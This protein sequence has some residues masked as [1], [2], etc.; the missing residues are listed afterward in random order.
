M[1]AVLSFAHSQWCKLFS[2]HLVSVPTPKATNWAMYISPF[3]SI[4][5]TVFSLCQHSQIFLSQGYRNGTFYGYSIACVRSKRLFSKCLS[6]N[7]LVFHVGFAWLFLKTHD[8][9]TSLHSRSHTFCSVSHVFWV[10]FSK[11]SFSTHFVPIG[12]VTDKVL[13]I[14]CWLHTKINQLF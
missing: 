11:A 2:R 4:G 12:S 10:T 3:S 1:Q 14:F 9:N 5:N 6:V 13:L 8:L 7:F